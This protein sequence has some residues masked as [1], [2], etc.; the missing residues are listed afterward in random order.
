M[1]AVTQTA[2]LLMA[3]VLAGAAVHKLAA[4]DRLAAATGRLLRLAPP[5]ARPVTFA[6]AAL[7]GAAALA[8]LYPPSRPL[9]ALIAACLWLAYG[10]ALLAAR[11]RGESM[12][13]CGCSFAA[14][15]GGIDRF[16]LLRPFALALLAAGLAAIPSAP[17][18]AAVEPIFAALALYALLL[19]AGELAA[20]PSPRRS[21]AR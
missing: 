9:G 5:L 3:I 15:R 20:L 2:A 7:E 13:D 21:H 10:F 1:G 18:A 12:M 19:A 11:R 17:M 8:L 4:T 14:R 16:T 6:A